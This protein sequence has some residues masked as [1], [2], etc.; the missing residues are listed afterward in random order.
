MAAL[1][2]LLLKPSVA[3]VHFQVVIF[4]RG[5]QWYL[6]QSTTEKSA[7]PNK[8]DAPPCPSKA[9]VSTPLHLPRSA[10]L[11][12]I[13]L[14]LG[15]P[16]KPFFGPFGAPGTPRGPLAVQPPRP[17]FLKGAPAG[18]GARLAPAK[19]VC[20]FEFA[21][22]LQGK[23]GT[24][25]ISALP[26]RAAVDAVRCTA[27]KATLL[28]SQPCAMPPGARPVALARSNSTFTMRR[29][30]CKANCPPRAGRPPLSRR[31]PLGRPSRAAGASR[32]AI[33]TRALPRDCWGKSRLA[34]PQHYAGQA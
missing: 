6:F 19:F 15:V 21:R 25:L 4:L 12:E 11:G 1:V 31:P 27:V 14:S 9:P 3:E 23:L 20:R 7:H 8:R 33:A 24:Y 32:E 17:N 2:P 30:S 18:R 13:S 34:K 5:I 28:R 16:S 29:S 10:R 26:P 22:P